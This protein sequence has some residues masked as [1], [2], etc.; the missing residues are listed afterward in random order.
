MFFCPFE[1]RRIYA[2]RIGVITTGSYMFSLIF[3]FLPFF[4]DFRIKIAV[5]RWGIAAPM[6]IRVFICCLMYLNIIHDRGTFIK[7]GYWGLIWSVVIPIFWIL[8]IVL[9]HRIA[10]FYESISNSIVNSVISNKS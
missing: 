3:L 6:V 9:S 5:L 8:V 1:I 10:K 4:S 2:Q 7:S